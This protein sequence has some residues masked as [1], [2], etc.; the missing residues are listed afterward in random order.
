MQVK[1]HGHAQS[2][3]HLSSA[4]CD[5][6]EQN[7]MWRDKDP[8]IITKTTGALTFFPKRTVINIKIACTVS[9]V[10]SCLQPYFFPHISSILFLVLILKPFRKAF[11]GMEAARTCQNP[12]EVS[13]THSS[14]CKTLPRP[15]RDPRGIP[16]TPVMT[17]NAYS[18]SQLRCGS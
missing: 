15:S 3:G 9:F 17:R 7:M 14:P 6:W 11:D 2:R 13:S 1:D 16:P 4:R 5:L 10:M 8:P 18:S 12:R